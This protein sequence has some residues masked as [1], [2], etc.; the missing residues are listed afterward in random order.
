MNNHLQSNQERKLSRSQRKEKVL[1]KLKRDSAKECKRIVFTLQ[2]LDDP[3]H[4]FKIN[5]NAQQLALNGFLMKPSE[6]HQQPVIIA[7]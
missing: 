1:R 3:A 5:K 7:I 6:H 4:I 2:K